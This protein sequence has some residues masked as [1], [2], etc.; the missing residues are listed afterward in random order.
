M[1]CEQCGEN[2]G[3]G[4]RRGRTPRFCSS[5]CRQKAY[6]SRKAGINSTS[7]SLVEVFP[8]PMASVTNWVRADGKRPICVDG[9]PASTTSPT[10]WSPLHEVLSSTVGDGFGIMLGNGA[11][12]ACHVLSNALDG[13]GVLVD[14][15]VKVLVG[16]ES[17]LFVEVSQN[18]RGLHVFV[19]SD[20]RPGARRIM[21]GGGR[22]EFYSKGR[23]IRTTG[24]DFHLTRFA[25]MRNRQ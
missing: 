15:A 16:I 12:I 8:E 5:A 1:K 3:I 18:R 13:D 23:F 6:R 11:G 2:I 10:T 7:K 24:E 22:H 9:T 21:P 25:D 20:E 17:P 19:K 14:W 4:G